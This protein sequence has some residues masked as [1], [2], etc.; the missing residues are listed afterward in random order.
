ML[1]PTAWTTWASAP[2]CGIVHDP[3]KDQRDLYRSIH[4]QLDDLPDAKTNS[5]AESFSC[6]KWMLR[7][8]QLH[9]ELT[10][11]HKLLMEPHP[12]APP[13]FHELMGRWMSFRS[14]YNV[15]IDAIGD[16]G[17]N[18]LEAN[19]NA[20]LDLLKRAAAADFTKNPWV[21][22]AGITL[23]DFLSRPMADIRTA[24]DRVMSAAV[25]A[26]ATADP[27]ILPFTDH[28]PVSKSGVCPRRDLG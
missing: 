2:L 27:R 7:L 6:K 4:Q 5:S 22:C 26:D 21:K 16:H 20:L 23:A 19:H 14:D 10:G 8:Q 18:E 24:I 9:D 13:S 1:L 28:A 12:K 11:F 3:Q 25:S 17:C 15:K